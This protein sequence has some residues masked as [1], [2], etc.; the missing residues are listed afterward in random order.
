MARSLWIF[1]SGDDLLLNVSGDATLLDACENTPDLDVFVWC[2]AHVDVFGYA[3]RLHFEGTH[4]FL[5]SVVIHHFR[6][7]FEMYS[8]ASERLLRCTTYEYTN[9]NTNIFGGA[10]IRMSAGM[11]R[12]WTSVEKH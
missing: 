6:T 10:P 9:K 1:V 12:F 4:H 5:I 8:T 2:T 7:F 11:H 3:P